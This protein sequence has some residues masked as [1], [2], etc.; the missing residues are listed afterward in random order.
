MEINYESAKCMLLI[1]SAPGDTG[2][3]SVRDSAKRGREDW[4]ALLLWL[5]ND[6]T[7][8]NLIQNKRN[9]GV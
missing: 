8:S 1:F 4:K 2:E 6:Q 7:V 9:A 3:C 5:H